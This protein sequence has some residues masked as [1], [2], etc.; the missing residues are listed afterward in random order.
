MLRSTSLIPQHNSATRKLADLSYARCAST[1]LMLCALLLTNLIVEAAARPTPA[2]ASNSQLPADA[3]A[4]VNGTPIPERIISAFLQNGQ[5]ALGIDANTPEGKA[6][7]AELRHHIVEEQIDRFLV[8]QEVARRR[9]A[10]DEKEV[11][12]AE[13]LR[14]EAVNGS[15]ERYAEFLRKNN[16]SRDD[17]RQYVLRSDLSGQAMAAA[18]GKDISISEAEIKEYYE[19]HKGDPDFQWPERATV[20]HI[21]LGTRPGV[22]KE[23]LKIERKLSDG[24]E[25]EQAVAAEVARKEKLAHEIHQQALQPDADFGALAAKYSEDFG[26]RTKGGSLGTAAR[27]MRPFDEVTFKLKPGEIGPVLKTEFGYHIVKLL[28]LRPAETRTLGEKANDI[29]ERLFSERQA[30]RMREWLKTAR[31]KAKV[32]VRPPQESAPV[33]AGR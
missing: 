32:I 3:A 33:A 26:S 8:A 14:L 4:L 9:I 13:N 27:G 24:P 10:P 2:S 20:A 30:R 19:A 15:Q 23:Q 21:L 7:L 11:D 17:Y 12:A 29:R 5:E 16:F 25:L 6:K 1:C 22:L 18:L 31:A 28:D